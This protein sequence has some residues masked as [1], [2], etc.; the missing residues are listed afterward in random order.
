MTFIAIGPLAGVDYFFRPVVQI[1]AGYTTATFVST[2]HA[3][4]I[5]ARDSCQ[6]SFL[7]RRLP[8]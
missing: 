7:W 5:A 1:V 8:R 2:L 3:T 6:C 4:L